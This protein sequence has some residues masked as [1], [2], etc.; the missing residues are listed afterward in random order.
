MTS[1]SLLLAA[2]LLAPLAARGQ[3]AGSVTLTAPDGTAVDVV[4][5]T[6]G[7]P[8]VYGD[9]EVGVFFGQG[10]AAAQD[11]LFQMETFW[12][13]ATGRL[14]EAFGP[15]FVEA[16]SLVRVLFY[17]PAEREAQF[18]ALPEPI[19]DMMTAYAAGVNTYIDSVAANPATYR[20]FEYTQ[21]PLSVIG[22]EPWDADKM[23]AVMQFFMRRFGEAGGEELQ[24]LAEL[25]ANG[26]EWFDEH[27][28][29]NDPTA[30]T[31]IEGGPAATPR[32]VAYRG[33][34]VDP[35]LA[36]AVRA[37]HRRVERRYEEVGIPRKFG[38]YAAA[39]GD[40]RTVWDA[41]MLLGAPQMGPP[42]VGGPGDPSRAV[43]WEAEL[44]VGEVGGGGLHVAGMTV[45]GIPGII[46]GRTADRTWTL[47]SGVS[48]NVDTFVETTEDASF[49]RYLFEGEYVD[50]EAIEETIPVLGGAP[51]TFTH[52]RTVHGPVYA[53]DLDAQQ[54]F[55]WKYTFW[56]RELDMATAFY[57]LWK[58]ESASEVEDALRQVPMSFNFL[59]ASK[60][61]DIRYWH[62]GFYPARPE[63]ADPRLPLLGDG[64]QE[65]DGLLAF[66]ELPQEAN[67][68]RGYYLNWNNKPVAWWDHGDIMPWREGAGRTYDGVLDLEAFVLAH[69]PLEY[70][71]LSGLH[72]VVD[73][74]EY[75][76]TYQQLV[77]FTETHSKAA[78]L[79][80]P[81]QSAFFNAQG[82][83]S[84]HV[85]DQWPLY[86]TYTM[87][88]FYFWGD[89]TVAN[90]P[91][92]ST[93]AEG[94]TLEAVYPNPAGS[95]VTV[96]Y[97]APRG[98]AVRVEVVDT[99]GRTVAVLAD[100]RADGPQER[101]LDTGA[102]AAG[103]YV[104]RLTADGRTL[105]RKLTV[106][107]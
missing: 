66:E 19:R 59:L 86:L 83:P 94:L 88:P 24:R 98:E 22:P 27:R 48:D 26:P 101:S 40:S 17:T 102:L 2:L 107:R 89:P 42:A 21:L 96:R 100:G 4:R 76:G 104:L 78:N 99:L 43:T 56:N 95:A 18:D 10:F 35:A 11:R 85:A 63:G 12:R 54:A 92:G 28:P 105:T 103:V 9:T 29:I 15:A 71:E 65:W 49:G 36:G 73:A 81:G 60:A 79:V 82:Q 23:V 58:A 53:A 106:V 50:F 51:V 69:T 33:P 64:S 57:A 91:D 75:P 13:A 30:P 72:E 14:A 8:H 7:V 77:L 5:D 90:E 46:I 1:R 68:A 52:Y 44:F 80:P 34:A 6:W 39:V 93:P 55:A 20:P 16:D 87:K 41:V 84:P 25:E 67:A 97:A 31:T 3:A 45:P 32:A 74:R 47:T 37:Q 61:Q 38:S 62:L 70:D